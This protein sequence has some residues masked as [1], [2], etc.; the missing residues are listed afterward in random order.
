MNSGANHCGLDQLSV[1][2]SYAN[3]PSDVGCNKRIVS[4][5]EPVE[6]G[7]EARLSMPRTMGVVVNFSPVHGHISRKMYRGRLY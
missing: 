6:L 5:S 3:K 7:A 4:V 2:K 1:T